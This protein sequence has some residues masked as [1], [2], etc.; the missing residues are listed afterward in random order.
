MDWSLR[1]LKLAQIER[2]IKGLDCITIPAV[3][4]IKNIREALGMNTRQLG[5]RCNISSERIVKIESDESE[6]KLTMATLEKM[7]TAM[8][9][10]FVY[11]FV[12]NDG[13]INTIERQAYIKAKS[14]LA[15]I[16][17]S[18]TLENQK[19]SNESMNEQI[20]LL[21]EELIKGNIKK[22]WDN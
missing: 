19:I 20:E 2:Q 13:L 11:G 4:W 21:K 3:G 10:K 15:R 6:G 22:I 17:H 16:S 14:Q 8:N 12:P 9:C 5:E 1:K 7:A 18:M